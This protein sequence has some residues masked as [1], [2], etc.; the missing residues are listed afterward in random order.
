VGHVL[1]SSKDGAPNY[2]MLH[3]DPMEPGA[4]SHANTGGHTH[5]WEHVVFILEGCGTLV[6]D[7]KS[8]TVSQGDAVLVP[9][10]VRHQWRNETR[11]TLVRATFNP[12]AS[13]AHES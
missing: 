9:P 4:V 1:I 8:Y 3:N 10:N 13:E 11:S 7:G 2:V 6:C 5:Q 12:V